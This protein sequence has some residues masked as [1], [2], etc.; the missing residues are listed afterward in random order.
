[1]K[2]TISA[3][4]AAYV[5][6][7]DRPV[8]AK[9]LLNIAAGKSR[10]PAPGSK[11]DQCWYGVRTGLHWAAEGIVPQGASVAEWRTVLRSFKH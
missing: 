5:N 11:L 10:T 8:R 4:K 6:F 7:H 1:M 9:E 3:A 2:G